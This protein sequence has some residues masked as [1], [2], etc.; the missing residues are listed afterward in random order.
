MTIANGLVC[1][2]NTLA[3]RWTYQSKNREQN[4]N[5]LQEFPQ[6]LLW[7]SIILGSFTDLAMGYVT[8]ISCVFEMKIVGFSRIAANHVTLWKLHRS[9]VRSVLLKLWLNENLKNAAV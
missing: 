3:A 8:I 4:H 1:V 6:S 9:W 5:C 2:T 7:N